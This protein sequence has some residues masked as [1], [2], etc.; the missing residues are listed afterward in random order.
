M[1]S[2][3]NFDVY[4]VSIEWT[5]VRC[6]WDEPPI[7]CTMDMDELDDL[8]MLRIGGIH[9]KSYLVA[10]NIT[11][12]QYEKFS[13]CRG[14]V[15][16]LTKIRE[17]AIEHYGKPV[18]GFC[19]FDSDGIPVECKTKNI[20]EPQAK[21][22]IQCPECDVIYD[23]RESRNDMIRMEGQNWVIQPKCMKC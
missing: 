17:M 22:R 21:I 13:N 19:S 4:F 18:T 12:K 11:P 8:K 23:D 20:E 1:P 10:V 7:T 2:N 14:A 9:I 3:T 15:Y 5:N 16:L 6:H